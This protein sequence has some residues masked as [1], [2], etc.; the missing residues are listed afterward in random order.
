M[1]KHQFNFKNFTQMTLQINDVEIKRPFIVGPFL[2]LDPKGPTAR[3]NCDRV[4]RV[5][6]G[7]A[8]GSMEEDDRRR[9]AAIASEPSL[10]PNF[11]TKNGVNAAQI[12]KFQVISFSSFELSN[13][14]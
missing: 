3:V 13:Q 1:I 9:E 14:T 2:F 10:Q 8:T 5:I 12:S 6:V 11:T 7:S 4:K